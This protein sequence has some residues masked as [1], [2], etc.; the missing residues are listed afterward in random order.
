MS[1][2]YPGQ[3]EDD[4]LTLEET[5]AIADLLGGAVPERTAILG[6][7][8]T[9]AATGGDPIVLR[10]DLVAGAGRKADDLPG[11][12]LIHERFATELGGEFRRTVGTEGSFIAERAKYAK[13]AEIYS[14]L[15]TP[16]AVAIANFSGIGG[17]IVIAMEVELMLHFLDLL[18]GGEGGYVVLRGD[19]ATRGFTPAER[20]LVAHVTGILSRALALAWSE[21]TPVYLDLVKVATDPRHAA[22]FE[23]SEA[24]VDLSVRVDWGVV[25]GSIRMFFPSAFLAPFESF[26]TRTAG[27]PSQKGE[28][29][30][31]EVMRN[32]LDPVTVEIAAILGS[33]EMTLSRLLNLEVGEVPPRRRPRRAGRGA[34]RGRAED[35][36]LPD[37][38]ARQ[39]RTDHRDLARRRRRRAGLQS[40]RRVSARQGLTMADPNESPRSVEFLLDVPLLVTVELGRSKMRIADLLKLSKGSVVEL[41]KIAGEPLDLRVNGQL[42]ARGEAVIVND[43]FGVRLTDV[44]S[45][46]ERVRS[47]R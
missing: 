24:M 36:R 3:D 6:P 9:G 17:Q 16:F 1:A 15:P 7:S 18:M 46:T 22:I 42:V 21:V 13:F 41:D 26:L 45:A 43:K 47:L 39:R 27:G 30:S 35:E 19:L 34:R 11:L 23:P 44:L 33:T 37:R 31:T 5:Q 8:F 38:A 32:N 10:Y 20:G 29:A 25:S 2:R 4:R 12:Q 28:S 40:T 14:R